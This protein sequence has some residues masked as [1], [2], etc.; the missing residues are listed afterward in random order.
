MRKSDILCRESLSMQPSREQR[1]L[2]TGR[3]IEAYDLA[4]AAALETC[5]PIGPSGITVSGGSQDED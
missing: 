1:G 4:N 3:K 2:R 5:L